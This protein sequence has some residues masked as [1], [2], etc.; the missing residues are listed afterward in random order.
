MRESRRPSLGPPQK[1]FPDQLTHNQCAHLTLNTSI[2]VYFAPN[3]L[4]DTYAGQAG[5]LIS[6]CRVE[7]RT[8][9]EVAY[10]LDAAKSASCHFAV[11]SG[12]HTGWPGASNADGGMTIAL[13]R[14]DHVEVSRNRGRVRLG[15]GGTWLGV[16]RA[17]GEY[18]L[19][20]VGGRAGTVGVGG[21]LLGGEC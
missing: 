7:P 6:A 14:I 10:A 18:G 17:L 13:G 11:R 2:P 4:P 20:V 16:Y 8:P 1:P 15:S 9:E 12:G 21:L 19:A 3:Q 5:E